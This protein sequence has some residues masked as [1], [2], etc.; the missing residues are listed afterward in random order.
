VARGQ[1]G[2]SDRQRALTNKVAGTEGAQA[3]QLEAGLIPKYESMMDEGYKPEELNAMRTAGLGA[4]AASADTAGWAAGNR[5]SRT[6]NAAGLGAE[7]SQLARDKGVTMGDT[8][9]NIE[10]ANANARLGNEKFALSGE[11]GLFGTNTGAMESLYGMSPSLLQARAAG[12]GWS[13]GFRDVGQG[14]G[15]VTKG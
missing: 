15:A 2:A 4:E 11:E 8:A 7:E 5:A 3:S 13:Q 12:G 1:A 10:L 6:G 9:A 14:I